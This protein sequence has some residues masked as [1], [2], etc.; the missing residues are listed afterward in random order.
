M[1]FLNLFILVDFLQVAEITVCRMFLGKL[2]DVPF[3]LL[4][5]IF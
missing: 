1:I 4:N 3:V 5:R 2:H